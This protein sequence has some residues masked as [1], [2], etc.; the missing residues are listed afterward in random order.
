MVNDINDITRKVATIRENFE[1]YTVHSCHR[2]SEEIINV[3]AQTARNARNARMTATETFHVNALPNV[4][5]FFTIC[6]ARAEGRSITNDKSGLV[7][8]VHAPVCQRTRSSQAIGDIILVLDRENGK[9]NPFKPAI[10]VVDEDARSVPSEL[11]RSGTRSHDITVPRLRLEDI[12][13]LALRSYIPEQ[14]VEKEDS[15]PRR[16]GNP[17]CI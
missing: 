4:N 2:P 11:P 5:E 3:F 14:R 7:R 6:D 1:G 12:G 10:D 15:L 13:T 9:E 16:V 8:S 17:K